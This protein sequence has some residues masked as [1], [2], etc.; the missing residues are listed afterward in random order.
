MSMLLMNA[1]GFTLRR[2][3][4]AGQLRMAGQL[5]MGG[6]LRMMCSGAAS[7]KGFW[8]GNFTPKPDADME[9]FATGYRAPMIASLEPFGGK[10]VMAVPKPATAYYSGDAGFFNWIAEFPSVQAAQDW[11]ESDAY[12]ALIPCRDKHITANY[13]IA[14]GTGA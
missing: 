8:V 9:E 4:M 2:A 12:K 5:P 10:L 7:K 3:P 14:E 6:Q 13:L 1:I 11:H